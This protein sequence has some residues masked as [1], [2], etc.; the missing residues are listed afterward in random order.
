MTEPTTEPTV[1]SDN[2]VA[3]RLTFADGNVVTIKYAFLDDDTLIKSLYGLYLEHNKKV[4]FVILYREE[5]EDR[6][7]LV[8]ILTSIEKDNTVTV[9]QRDKFLQDLTQ[10]LLKEK[11]AKENIPA[12]ILAAIIPA[13]PS[14]RSPI[15]LQSFL[16]IFEEQD[17]NGGILTAPIIIAS[18]AENEKTGAVNVQGVDKAYFTLRVLRQID[19]SS[20]DTKDYGEDDG[21]CL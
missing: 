10:N 17:G 8:T 3:V 5:S 13:L 7:P 15:P 12:A 2:N 11:V 20:P 9:M 21:L 16:G 14:A 4:Q 1:P 18:Y 19:V 6:P